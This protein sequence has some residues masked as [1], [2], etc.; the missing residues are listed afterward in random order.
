MTKRIY[1]L[2]FVV[3]S[4]A[5]G[6][7]P[8]KEQVVSDSV[9]KPGETKKV[10]ASVL[11]MGLKNGGAVQ[12]V[13]DNGKYYLKITPHEKLGFVENGSLELKSGSKSFFVKNAKL[14]NI[15]DPGA[16]F[17]TEIFMNYVATL[18]DNGLTGLVFNQFE[19]KFNKEDSRK[20]E[21]TADCFYKLY[22]K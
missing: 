7:Q 10:I 22:K 19:I 5:A 18:K 9:L 3:C 14:Y 17:I 4:L 1:I 2:L 6:A 12:F 20:V 8:C 11:Y 16:Y 13:S 21:E 15:K